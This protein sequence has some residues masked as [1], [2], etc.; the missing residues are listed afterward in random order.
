MEIGLQSYLRQEDALLTPRR[1]FNS[2]VKKQ[3]GCLVPNGIRVTDKMQV[4]RYVDQ[5]LK[6]LGTVL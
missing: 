5:V 1:P 4:P 6:Y 3:E 2:V